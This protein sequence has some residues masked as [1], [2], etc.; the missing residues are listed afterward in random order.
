MNYDLS[1]PWLTLDNWQAEYIADKGDC[2]LICG[3]QSGKTTAMSIK[4]GDIATSSKS[5]ILIGAFTE[6]Q[7]Y[8]LFFKALTYIMARY[9]EKLIITGKDKPTKHEFRLKNG[10][11]VRAYA[12]GLTGMGMRTFTITHLFIDECR[13]IAREVFV[14][15]EPMLSVTKGVK[16]YASTPGGKQGYFYEMSKPEHGFRIFHISAED[17]PRHTKEFLERQK[18]TMTRIE[19]AQEYL[20][21]FMDEVMRVFSDEMLK[22]I[23]VLVRRSSI[24][25]GRYYGGVDIGRLGS[26][27]STF[28]IFEKINETKIE[29]VENI[30]T[31]KTLTTE[32]SSKIIELQKAFKC[33]KWGL[34]GAGVGGGVFDQC[35]LSPELRYKTI[36]LLNATRPLDS[37]G[38]KTKRLLKE[39]MYVNLLRLM[40]MKQIKLLNDEDLIRSLASVL[41]EYDDDGKMRIFGSY[42]HIAEGIIR[43]A[44][45]CAQDKSLNLWASYSND[46]NKQ[47]LYR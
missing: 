27:E 47:I 20:G 4:I 42:T 36:D 24:Q 18:K 9:P 38:K 31:V 10:T 30:V 34:D 37:D 46:V 11:V 33:K 13:E 43:S 15:L 40:E 2:E 41:Y 7:A 3:R 17:C 22:E 14:S 45:L 26:S 39:E 28:E 1:R 16:N 29:Q 21:E 8:Q 23:C 32:T 12:L 19:Y 5:D 44:W 6:K 25:Q 35:L